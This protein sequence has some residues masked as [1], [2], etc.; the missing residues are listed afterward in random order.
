MEY[1]WHRY[2]VWGNAEDGYE[3]N[4][5]YPG[6]PVTLSDTPS[7]EEIADTL[8]LGCTIDIDFT[9]DIIFV[10]E[11]ATGKPIGQLQQKE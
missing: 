4:D 8:D 2:D 9:E 11:A 7:D 10:N 6:T 3:V 1:T 5:I